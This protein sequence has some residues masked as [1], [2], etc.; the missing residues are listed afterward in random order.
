MIATVFGIK[1]IIAFVKKVRYISVANNY[2]LYSACLLLVLIA[3][4]VN[5]HYSPL[6]TT[7]SCWCQVYNLTPEDIAFENALQHIPQDASVTASIE[8]RTHVNHRENVWFVPSATQSAQYI[9]LITQNRIVGNYNPKIY[10]NQLIPILLKNTKYKVDF[11]SQ[12]FYL[13]QKL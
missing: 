5:Y 11:K 9:A 8:V 4:R 13:F 3:L 12:H 6:P 7:P 2:L 10:E 1:Y